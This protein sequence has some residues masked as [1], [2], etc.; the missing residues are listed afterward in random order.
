MSTTLVPPT[1]YI[2]KQPGRSARVVKTIAQAAGA[3]VILGPT[4]AEV[5]AITGARTRRLTPAEQNE[6]Q[7]HIRAQRRAAA[8]PHAA[9]QSHARPP[10]ISAATE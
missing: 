2:V 4:P 7:T 3:V 9:Q 1:H 6:L 8:Q 5:I 10:R